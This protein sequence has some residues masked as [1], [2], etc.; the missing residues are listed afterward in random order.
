[1]GY[2]NIFCAIE[3][4]GDEKSESA[5]YCEKIK[6]LNKKVLIN[7]FITLNFR[8]DSTEKTIPTYLSSYVFEFSF[9]TRWETLHSSHE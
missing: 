9:R 7:L 6:E 4:S 1:M 8:H 3:L 2:R 5:G